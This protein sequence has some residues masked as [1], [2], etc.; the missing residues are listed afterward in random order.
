MCDPL[1]KLPVDPN[2]LPQE[3]AAELA[4]REF[5]FIMARRARAY[6]EHGADQ[7]FNPTSESF[8]AA[9][10]QS[11]AS[12]GE[13][14]L[15]GLTFSG[16][17][18]R[19]ATFGLGVLQGLADLGLLRYFD[20]LST[21]SGGGYIGGWFAA[22]VKREGSLE[23]VARQLH[24]E[25][26]KQSEAER[27]FGTQAIPVGAA[28]EPEPEPIN[29]L[30]VFS[31]Y[32][33][34]RLSFFSAD[35]WTL[36]T[37]YLRN[38]AANQL[39]LLPLV[40]AVVLLTR[41]I[42]KFFAWPQVN[43]KHPP[44]SFA[45]ASADIV[46]NTIGYGLGIVGSLITFALIGVALWGLRAEAKNRI[47]ENWTPSRS[48]GGW[49]MFW[50]VGVLAFAAPGVSWMYS[51][52][53]RLCSITE[54]LG[55]HW[56]T[57]TF[58]GFEWTG[59]AFFLGLFGVPHFFAHLPSRSTNW[60]RFCALVS[61]GVGGAILY[62]IA[63]N[64]LGPHR[65]EPYLIATIGP[66][67][68]LLA[69]VAAVFSEVAL[70]GRG[71]D[72][73]ER[74]W[75]SRLCAWVMLVATVWAVV[76]GLSLYGTL[77]LWQANRWWQVAL[78]AGWMT[79][80]VGGVLA[81][82]SPKTDGHQ[83]NQGRSWMELVAMVAPFVFLVGLGCAM[84]LLASSLV[85]ADPQAPELAESYQKVLGSVK[86]VEDR[87]LEPDAPTVVTFKTKI[88]ANEKPLSHETIHERRVV[89]TP[90]VVERTARQYWWGVAN[91]KLLTVFLWFVGAVFVTL[92]AAWRV[93]INEFSLNAMYANR[94]GRCY[95]GASRR[96]TTG[97]LFGIPNHSHGRVRRPN[98]VTGFDPDD[99][100][101]LSQ[102]RIGVAPTDAPAT[103]DDGVIRDAK[104]APYWG[105]FPLLNTALNLVAGDQLA[106]QERMAESFVLSPL[107]CGANSLGYRDAKLFAA[108]PNQEKPLT[109]GRAVAIS[110]AAANPN[111]G[112]NCSPAAAALMTIFNVR[113]G[114]WLPNPVNEATWNSPGP[115]FGLA[116]LLF[117]LFGYTHAK[118]RYLNISDGG[119]FE[120]LG[121]Y[122][123][124]RRRCRYIVVSDA[125]ADPNSEFEDLAG[126]IRKCRTD[127]G[128]DIEID[129]DQL[130]PAANSRHSPRHCAIGTIRYDQV[131]PQLPAG[132]LIYL[133]PVLSGN[134]S[135]D[136]Q[137]YAGRHADFPHQP[138]LDQFFNESQ[139]ESYR[140][141]GQHTV[142]EAFREVVVDM[143]DF[144]RDN[145]SDL[146]VDD[147]G[148][149]VNLARL[150]DQVRGRHAKITCS[151]FYRLKHHWL[152]RPP[153]L[154]EQF[155]KSVEG[156]VAL[157]TDLRD[158]RELHAISR[159]LYRPDI[160]LA[161][162]ARAVAAVE[163]DADD[164]LPAAV[165]AHPVATAQAPEHPA[166][167][168]PLDAVNSTDLHTASLMLQAME[169]ALVGAQL[170]RHHANPLNAGWMNVFQRWSNSSL[171]RRCWPLLRHDYSREFDRFC[172]R[173]LSLKAE[174][175]PL[176]LWPELPMP[177]DLTPIWD[178]L[179]AEFQWEWPEE[180]AA[181]PTRGLVALQAEAHRFDVVEE[182]QVVS[183]RALWFIR[184]RRLQCDPPAPNDPLQNDPWNEGFIHGVIGLRPLLDDWKFT[185]DEILRGQFGPPARRPAYELFIWVRPG[186]RQHGAGQKLM[187]QFIDKI[188][189][190]GPLSQS[191]APGA[192]LIVSYPTS[193]WIGAGNRLA[194]SQWMSL[195]SY[196]GFRKPGRDWPQSDGYELLMMQTPE[197]APADQ[198]R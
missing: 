180:V 169:N 59:F 189:D 76:M 19:S 160:D 114:W 126:L 16:G 135:A 165:A 55:W 62:A 72:E 116:W 93:D 27:G 84:S 5:R 60:T 186:F 122:E 42:V 134:E 196:Y 192:R 37:V 147:N 148:A 86:S 98:S 181:K 194:R 172:R 47:D 85:D 56:I 45:T 64:L 132:L 143:G 94:L 30:R 31:N 170:E 14:N 22:W 144:I 146:T 120:N 81:A 92:I 158:K 155:L 145:S 25:R 142:S 175:V 48:A 57:F 159:D 117:E 109:V 187:E 176:E 188:W 95:L 154:E 191:L 83:G 88:D 58:N 73:Q 38:F 78:A 97:D 44:S 193:G 195:F 150:L 177:A 34:P 32:L 89:R 161:P 105:P 77:W 197:K 112:Y 171:L 79:S 124:V 40:L 2:A 183:R 29:H 152:V 15:V 131:D 1:E 43:F 18:I 125:G 190:N 7:D 41:F 118:S 182:G 127:F 69:F 174:F 10:E 123:L 6:A 50:I 51:T 91:A 184:G 198:T 65:E 9:L 12:K 153:Q 75:W 36:V 168:E 151:L 21:V 166:P 67:A 8:Q 140:A 52:P 133:K 149:A 164:T 39:V 54:F 61:G 82:R 178:R 13:R 130:R 156:F 90:D 20:Y 179:C 104:N 138:T 28:R 101:A 33:S 49:W 99:D 68:V 129:V 100:F 23:N 71:A 70:M 24:P 113:L 74:E 119:H 137:H 63:L 80:A 103:T 185:R 87:K 35:S 4:N 66:P 3:T 110:G 46:V 136:V 115:R 26:E 141:L 163:Q 121:V 106:W 167:H 162:T 96:K 107:Y 111:M 11:W 128:V 53:E 102:L 139:F 157:Q 17:G 108:G 173:E